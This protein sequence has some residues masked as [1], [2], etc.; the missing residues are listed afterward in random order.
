MSN[1]DLLVNELVR[2]GPNGL[3]R[4]T[5][6]STS[7][8]FCSK[9]SNRSQPSSRPDIKN[10]W[11]SVRGIVPQRSKDE[12]TERKVH[13]DAFSTPQGE[14]FVRLRENWEAI[15]REACLPFRVTSIPVVAGIDHYSFADKRGQSFRCCDNNFLRS[16]I[17][18]G[19]ARVGTSANLG[20]RPL[21]P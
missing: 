19:F 6:L 16:S 7:A 4:E 20:S 9:L 14:N 8:G 11:R 12:P 10:R 13:T 3:S 1:H 15:R 18:N 2:Y 5:H 21:G 17:T